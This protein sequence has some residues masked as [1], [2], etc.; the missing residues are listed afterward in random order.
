MKIFIGS[1]NE[2]IHVAAEIARTIELCGH[3]PCLWKDCF[4]PTDFTFEKILT[5]CNSVD[6][7]IFVLAPDDK[8]E[9]GENIDAEYIT[10]DNV[11][12]EAGIFSGKLGKSRMALC[13]LPN[14]KVPS[15]FSGIT[16]IPYR[17]NNIHSVR[18]NIFDWIQ[19]VKQSMDGGNN[20]NTIILSDR[21]LDLPDFKTL[22]LSASKELVISSFFISVLQYSEDLIYSKADSINVRFLLPDFWG[23]NWMATVALLDGVKDDGSRA[24]NKMQN[25]LSLLTKRYESG[26]MP[27]NFE[28]R[29]IDSVLPTPV[30]MVDPD[31]P[32]GHM[33]VHVSTYENKSAPSATFHLTKQ[34]YL[35]EAYRQK[36]EKA[37]NDARP[38][39]FKQVR[40]TFPK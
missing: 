3:E 28:I 20:D 2:Y 29:L 32:Q 35:F 17:D 1:S 14:T 15:D 25:T 26:Q 31:L 19:D 27:Q 34:Q 13:K 16:Y 12:I 30:T 7:G 10:R 5:I 22:V 38:I 39:D 4:R 33:Y 40:S 6:A 9:K 24:E 36:L 23:K 11:L 21:K 37:W 18:K 8:M